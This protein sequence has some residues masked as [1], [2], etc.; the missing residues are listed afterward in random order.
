MSTAQFQRPQPKRISQKKEDYVN[1]LT[2]HLHEMAKVWDNR[3]IQKQREK[4]AKEQ[5]EMRDAPEIS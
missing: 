1:S 4:E 3:K 2:T 5:Q